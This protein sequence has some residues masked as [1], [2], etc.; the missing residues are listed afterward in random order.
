MN[1][2]IDNL[3]VETD[4]DKYYP[5]VPAS[6]IKDIKRIVDNEIERFDSYLIYNKSHNWEIFKIDTKELSRW[7]RHYEDPDVYW[8]NNLFSPDVYWDNNLFSPVGIMFEGE[9]AA[10]MTAGTRVFESKLDRDIW[11]KENRP[12]VY[13][14]LNTRHQPLNT[15]TFEPDENAPPVERFMVRYFEEIG[16]LPM[17]KYHLQFI[18]GKYNFSFIRP[19]LYRLLVVK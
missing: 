2:I 17:W 3:S 6:E 7:K 12:L 15:I 13:S 11:L 5:P 16:K 9:C 18:I 10:P 4:P 1:V 8:D 19:F 14:I